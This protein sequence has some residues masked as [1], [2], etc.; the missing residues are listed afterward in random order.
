MSEISEHPRAAGS[1]QGDA[2]RQADV[3]TQLRI[4]R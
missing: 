2:G 4:S 3:R 1:R